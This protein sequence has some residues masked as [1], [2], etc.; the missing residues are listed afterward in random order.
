MKNNIKMDPLQRNRQY[1]ISL[2]SGFYLN[3]KKPYH[4]YQ[5]TII[6]GKDTN[7]QNNHQKKCYSLKNNGRIKNILEMK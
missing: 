3:Q 5:L 4:S 7:F 1:S 6:R 2:M